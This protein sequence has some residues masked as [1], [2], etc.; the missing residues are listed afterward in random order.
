MRFE[1]FTYKLYVFL[2]YDTHIDFIFVDVSKD[3]LRRVI[4]TYLISWM[5]SRHF[6]TTVL[7]GLQFC[8]DIAGHHKIQ[9]LHICIT[10]VW[11]LSRGAHL[12]RNYMPRR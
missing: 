4:R 9:I 5:G 12:K 10:V 3:L 11:M 2:I 7:V 6:L 1:A 8:M